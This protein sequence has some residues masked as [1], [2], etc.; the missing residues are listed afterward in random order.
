M[1][2]STHWSRPSRASKAGHP[3]AEIALYR[4]DPYSVRIRVI[5]PGFAACSRAERFDAVWES[6]EPLPDDLQD[7]ISLLLTFTP[8]EAEAAS[9]V[10]YDFDH[11][12]P[13][14]R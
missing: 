5:E 6:I 9:G 10:N 7:Q 14:G 12:L 4:R 3:A 1:I 8:E 11:P 13:S 2:R